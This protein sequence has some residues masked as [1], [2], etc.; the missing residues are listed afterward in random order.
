MK[1][2]QGHQ[3]EI[4][5]NIA[6]SFISTDNPAV[7]MYSIESIKLFKTN[8]NKAFN[9]REISDEEFEKAMK[10]LSRLAMRQIIDK[11]GHKK[12]VYVK[13]SV[14]EKGGSKEVDF[15]KEDLVKFT[16]DGQVIVGKIQSLKFNDKTDKIGTA[17]VVSD[18]KNYSVSLNKL[19]HHKDSKMGD[20]PEEKKLG[21]HD[22]TISVSNKEDDKFKDW[23]SKKHLVAASHHAEMSDE[24]Q[25]MKNKSKSGSMAEKSHQKM[26]DEH[27]KARKF[28]SDKYDNLK[29]NDKKELTPAEQAMLDSPEVIATK[30]A[31]KEFSDKQENQ[32]KN[33]EELS[34]SE[35]AALKAKREDNSGI[36]TNT[37]ESA[38]KSKEIDAKKEQSEKI[39]KNNK[40]SYDSIISKEKETIKK[41]KDNG[42]AS[43][44]HSHE[45]VKTAFSDF[46]ELGKHLISKLG[47]KYDLKFD[48]EFNHKNNEGSFEVGFD[49]YKLKEEFPEEYNNSSRGLA[50]SQINN[51][52]GWRVSDILNK[53]FS[54]G[55][56]GYTGSSYGSGGNHIFKPLVSFYAGEHKRD[57]YY[58]SAKRKISKGIDE[59][60]IQKAFNKLGSF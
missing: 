56:D 23:D 13:V 24:Y 9:S 49:K 2:I 32:G 60:S 28:H 51:F 36:K 6:K 37:Q 38:E 11:N 22:K 55:K 1:D 35:K 33:N 20:M 19:E 27:E 42:F 47:K 46:K 31:Q 12:I 3:R 41:L 25:E 58:N 54:F 5:N 59:L 17:N 4:K 14:D 18:G 57:G 39:L 15:D 16:K 48:F 26:I 29:S 52:A 21:I 40:E 8:L 43:N 50:S 45:M 53:E 30:K 44:H 10:D 7:E 34:A